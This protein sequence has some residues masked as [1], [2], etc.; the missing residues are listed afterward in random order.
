[1]K[2]LFSKSNTFGALLNKSKFGRST[3]FLA[4]ALDFD[5][6]RHTQA[7][8]YVECRRTDPCFG[9]LLRQRTCFHGVAEK[10]FITLHGKL[11]I[12]SKVITYFSLPRYAALVSKGLNMLVSLC[13]ASV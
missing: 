3:S 4:S 10:A 8:H 7:C 13:I 5:R 9:F 6:H 2:Q 1:M 11:N 12:A